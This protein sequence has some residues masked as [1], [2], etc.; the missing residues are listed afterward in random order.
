QVRRQRSAVSG[1]EVIEAQATV[2]F[3]RF[4]AR[5]A[6]TE[7]K[8][9]DPVH[10]LHALG[11]QSPALA[12]V[13]TSVLLFGAW[14]MHHRADSWFATLVGQQSSQQDLAVQP[15]RLGSPALTRGRDRRRIDDM[16]IH[17]L[18]LQNA[19]NP[20]SIQSCLLNRDEGIH[21]AGPNPSPLLQSRQ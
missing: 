12:T 8:A 4:E 3:E 7:E 18:A 1:L 19:M 11:D 15:V 6:L 20:E 9:L 5:H 21:L 14:C 17:A 2:T 13:A 16:T 10:D